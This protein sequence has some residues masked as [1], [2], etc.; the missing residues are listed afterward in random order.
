M[1]SETSEPTLRAVRPEDGSFLLELYGASRAD[2]LDQAAWAPG[3]REAFV[4]MQHDIQTGQ[5]R[6]AYPDGDFL[7]VEIAGRALGRLTL[8]RAPRRIHVVDLALMPEARGQGIG[9]RLLGAVLDEAAASGCCVSLCVEVHNG[10]AARLYERLGFQEVEER[11]IHRLLEWSPISGEGGL[12]A[13]S[14]AAAAH[15]DQEEGDGAEA[16]VSELAGALAESGRQRAG[17]HQRELLASGAVGGDAARLRAEP[18]LGEDEAHL[19]AVRQHHEERVAHQPG[20]VVEVP[21]RS[22]AASL[23]ERR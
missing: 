9:T 13:Q 2:E 14:V 4:R 3:Q 5:Y 18:G 19:V 11:G 15:G 10:G 6:A 1:T 12:V 16:R 20:E 17:E 21:P 7:V 22:H 8:A 23:G